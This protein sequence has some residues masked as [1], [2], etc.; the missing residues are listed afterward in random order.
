[1][2]AATIRGPSAAATTTF[3]LGALPMTIATLITW[4]GTLQVT[5]AGGLTIAAAALTGAGVHL[6]MA[7]GGALAGALDMGATPLTCTACG[8]SG[9]LSITANDNGVEIDGHFTVNAAG[10]LDLRNGRLKGSAQVDGP[11][12]T[13]LN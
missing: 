3:A 1:L 6:S 2:T 7:D 4:A 9:A 13:V 12:T 5:G 11:G 10:V 8:V